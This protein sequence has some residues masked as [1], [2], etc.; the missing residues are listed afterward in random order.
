MQLELLVRV[1]ATFALVG[2]SVTV[3]GFALLR[4]LKLRWDPLEK[5]AGSVAL[6]L[7]LIYLWAF[8]AFLMELPRWTAYAVTLVI[9]VAA[10]WSW[11]EARRMFAVR[12]VQTVIV[13]LALLALWVVALQ[14]V[15]RNYGGGEWCCDWLEHYQRTMNFVDPKPGGFLYIGRYLLPAR[16]PLMNAVAAHFLNQLG[17]DFALYQVVF[18]LLNML[19]FLPCCL[20]ARLFVPGGVRHRGVLA[21]LLGTNPMFYMNATFAWTKL[22]TAFFVIL[23]VWF[24]LVGA[25]RNSA[26][27]LVAAFASLAAAAM[28]H[29][30]ALPY[31]LFLSA[32]YLVVILRRQRRP[33]A[34]AAIAGGAVLAVVGPWFLWSLQNYGLAGTL[35]TNTTVTE[36][37]KF[38]W[39]EN[40]L[41]IGMNILDTIVPHWWTG[42]PA[43]APLR[44]LIDPPFMLFQNNLLFAPGPVVSVL[45]AWGISRRL[46]SPRSPVRPEEK[47]FWSLFIPF[48]IVVGIAVHGERD[49]S[50]VAHIT[51]Q[52]LVYMAIAYVAANVWHY[53]LVWRI[54]LWMGTVVNLAVGVFLHLYLEH[55][56][57]AWARTPN[58][59]WK[60]GAKVTFLGD[61]MAGAAPLLAL[62]IG[63]GALLAL[64]W[65][66]RVLTERPAE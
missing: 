34:Q 24:L 19:A 59:D 47:R 64:G 22:L 6:S 8:G 4:L 65:L 63:V 13:P 39:H 37:A 18:S 20:V 42:V 66:W 1:V 51:L 40:L 7:I 61:S 54:A 52:P 38:A 15:I 21:V 56:V 57:E 23:A 32:A 30:S 33:L 44:R 53:S 27:R 26:S 46:I 9:L 31:A 3:P 50:G 28:V 60:A 12:R 10:A 58:W 11:P 43:G 45:A 36:S 62:L 55:S 5:L 25:R 48:A 17:D 41:K 35:A 16:P 29:Y 49:D 2:L 14:A